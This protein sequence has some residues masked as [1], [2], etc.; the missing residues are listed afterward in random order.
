MMTHIGYSELR[1]ISTNV[2]CALKWRP[3]TQFSYSAEHTA[4]QE[5]LL[6]RCWT[7]IRMVRLISNLVQNGH[8][9]VKKDGCPNVYVVWLVPSDEFHVTTLKYAT[10]GNAYRITNIMI[11]FPT[12]RNIWDSV[13]RT[14][15]IIPYEYWICSIKPIVPPW[16]STSLT[17]AQ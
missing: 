16:Y 17:F 9:L 13:V 11:Q 2:D 5:I 14:F 3:L 15:I 7:E 1:L 10:I 4:H 8:F 6:P 12:N